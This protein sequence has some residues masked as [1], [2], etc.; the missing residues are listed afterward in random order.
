MKASIQFTSVDEHTQAIGDDDHLLATLTFVLKVGDGEPMILRAKVKS[1]AGSSYTNAPLEI[2]RPEGYK[3]PFNY[4]AYRKLAE[5][6]YRDRIVSMGPTANSKSVG[7][8]Q[9]SG[10]TFR[11][12]S[13]EQFFEVDESGAG[14]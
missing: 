2:G 1:P 5:R 6:F 11:V 4:A 7:K 12:S 3:G 9:M 10:N 13:P 14:W 8:I